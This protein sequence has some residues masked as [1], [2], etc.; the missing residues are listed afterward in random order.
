MRQAG[1]EEA[2]VGLRETSGPRLALT[3]EHCRSHSHATPAHLDHQVPLLTEEVGQPPP[4]LGAHLV[5][6]ALGVPQE[7][8]CVPICLEGCNG[9][10]GLPKPQQ[11]P[12]L[13]GLAPS[14]GAGGVLITT[15]V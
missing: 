3:M 14:N 8:Y 13:Q 11:G 7:S 6:L 12:G 1:H 2:R 5:Q 10:D 4:S 15:G 9:T